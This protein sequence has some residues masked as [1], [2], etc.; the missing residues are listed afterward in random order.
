MD[1]QTG[2][3]VPGMQYCKPGPNTR[4]PS[5]AQVTQMNAQNSMAG[6]APADRATH[7]DP[8]FAP[9][10]DSR[11]EHASYVDSGQ[12]ILVLTLAL[13]VA[14]FLYVTQSLRSSNPDHGDYWTD[15]GL[16]TAARNLN[17]YGFNKLHL[18][19]TLDNGPEV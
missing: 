16:I 17:A 19:V 10:R 4:D 15:M 18:G 12:V 9:A 8:L 11:S 1:T 13:A 2:F 5:N 3:N 6:D 14:G 7:C